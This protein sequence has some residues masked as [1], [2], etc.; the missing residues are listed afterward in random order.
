LPHG[1]EGDYH[2]VDIHV[3]LS[4]YADPVSELGFARSADALLVAAGVG[5]ESSRR[6]V[7]LS[8]EH[9]KHVRAFVGVHPSEVGREPEIDWLATILRRASGVGE[10]GL[11]PKYSQVG[12]GSAQRRVLEAQLRV[13][14]K[15]SKPV[16]VHSRGAEREVLD[17]LGTF[18]LKRVLLHWFQ[19]EE[20]AAEASAKGY[21]VSFGPA[22]LVSKKLQRMALAWDREGVLTESDGPVAFEALGGAG[23]PWL[24]PAIAFKLGLLFSQGFEDACLLIA[25]N[26]RTYLS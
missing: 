22:L 17:V 1:G 12:P 3:H 2:F 18:E 19:G 5:E 15:S 14:E 9:P 4:D 7:S 6:S 16:Q 20:A 23:G 10:V 25:Q 24:V 13:A 21:F 11:D 8:E 26:S